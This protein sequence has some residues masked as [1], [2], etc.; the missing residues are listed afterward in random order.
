MS[1]GFS[2]GDCIAVGTLAWGIYRKCK[3]LSDEFE[4]VCKEAL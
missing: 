2:V 1:F 3:G 4:D